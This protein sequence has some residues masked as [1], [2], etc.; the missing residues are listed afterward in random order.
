M[1]N[2]QLLNQTSGR[3]EYYTPSEIVEAARCVMGGIDFDPASCTIANRIVRATDYCTRATD[4]L[5]VPW[6]GRIWLN[7]PFGR[8]QNKLWINKL[9]Q[10]HRIGNTQQACCITF[11]STSETWFQP[12]FDFPL[13]FLSPRT[14]YLAPDGSTVRGVTKGS[15]VAGI[16]VNIDLFVRHFRPLGRIMLPC[17]FG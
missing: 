8:K 4:G 6:W 2:A 3:V 12:L 10:E 17:L 15:V 9:L 11:A 13:C 5:R 14:N 7:H 1:N 16:G